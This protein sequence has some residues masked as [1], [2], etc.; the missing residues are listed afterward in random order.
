VAKYRIETF[1]EKCTGCLRC[2]LACSDLYS[3]SFNPALSRIRIAI[4]IDDWAIELAEDCNE[5]AACVDHCFYGALQ[6][7]RKGVEA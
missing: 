5:C 1:D 3:G 7:G 4:S 6:R 2:A